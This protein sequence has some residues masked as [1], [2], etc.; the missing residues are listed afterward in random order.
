MYTTYPATQELSPFIE[1]YWHWTAEVNIA[2]RQFILPDAA[3]EFIVH[4]GPSP[5]AWSDGGW[6]R[7][8][9]A[10]LYCAAERCLELRITRPMDVFAIRFRPWGLSRF[11]RRPMADML[12]RPVAPD[13]ALGDLG[14]SLVNAVLEAARDGERLLVVTDLLTAT[15]NART[16][17]AVS[18]TI[19]IEALGGGGKPARELAKRLARSKR[20]VNR[21]WR[22]LVGI[23]PRGYAKLMRVHRALELIEQGRPLAA[24]AAECEFADQAHMARQIKEIAGLSPSRMQSWLGKQVYQNLYAQRPS[25]PWRVLPPA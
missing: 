24:V 12:D 16:D 10:F 9:R 18:I 5:E 14:D 4:L 7:Q 2:G 20:T 19:L 6:R 3:P 21:V 22:D 8:P 13:D 23:S 17:K 25:A 11:S 1:C 15:L